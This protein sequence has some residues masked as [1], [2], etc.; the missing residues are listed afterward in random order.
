MALHLVLE[1]FS[2]VYEGQNY[3]F[4][5]GEIVDDLNV[6]VSD[7]EGFGLAVV[8]YDSTYDEAIAAFNQKHGHDPYPPTIFPMLEAFGVAGFSRY[9]NV[10]ITAAMVSAGSHTVA[11]PFTVTQFLVTAKTAAGALKMAITDTFTIVGGDILITLNGGGGD[12]ADTDIVTIV[13]M[14]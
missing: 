3:A 14:P 11:F 12:L 4:R 7:L 1:L 9:A 8:G 6:P 10:T 2:G 13:A 5:P